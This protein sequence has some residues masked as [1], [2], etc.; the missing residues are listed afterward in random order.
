MPGF[1]VDPYEVELLTSRVRGDTAL[2]A[3]AYKLG[4]TQEG[5]Y[6]SRRLRVAHFW[7]NQAGRW[8]IASKR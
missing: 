5:H 2:T 8:R 3:G 6:Q 1:K 7:V 4:W